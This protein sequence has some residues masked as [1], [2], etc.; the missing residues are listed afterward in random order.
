M[1]KQTTRHFRNLAI[2]VLIS[3]TSVLAHAE[4]LQDIVN[5]HTEAMGGIEKLRAIKTQKMEA[6]TR[7]M[8]WMNVTVRN[9]IRHGEAIASSISLNGDESTRTIVTQKGGVTIEDGKQTPMDPREAASFMDD[10]DLSGPFVDSAKKGLTLK[11]IGEKT[12]DKAGKTYAIEVQKNGG[13]PAAVYY[14]RADN[15]LIAR[16][17]TKN[18]S[19][20]E[21][22]WED[23]WTE[24]EDYRSVDGIKLPYVLRQSE[25][26]IS[27]TSYKLNEALDS[28]VFKL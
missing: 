18:Y 6:G 3:G 24:Y 28:K 1:L 8:V 25:A 19:T 10:A 7:V 27:V 16:M 11:L 26:E 22:R 17:E 20:S 13:R 15:Y 9:W 23:T 14:I 12:I 2:A 4:S 21:G 5:R